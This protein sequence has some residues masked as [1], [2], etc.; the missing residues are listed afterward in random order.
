[1]DGIL[2]LR[3][4]V[5]MTSH[6]CV[7]EIR[8]MT[9]ERRV[10]HAGTLD[11]QVG[12]VLPICLGQATRVIEYLH[13]ESKMYNAVCLVGYS[14]Q[15]EDHTGLLL[16]KAA[17]LPEITEEEARSVLSTFLG[18]IEQTPPMYSAVKVKG[19]RLYEWAREGIEVERPARK[20][21]IHDLNLQK[22]GEWE[23]YPTIHFQVTCSKGTYIRTLCVDIGQKWGMPAHMLH[24][25][26][27]KSGP[28]FL[29]ETY[30]FEQIASAVAQ[31]TFESLLLPIDHAL[32][33][34][35]TCEVGE[36]QRF[37][38]INGQTI[39]FP[40]KP[41]WNQG[42]LFRVYSCDGKFLA[43]YEVSHFRQLESSDVMYGKPVKV[44]HL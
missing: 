23:G 39:A 43:L 9:G 11:P 22:I 2:P 14:T 8:R 29:E 28:F 13:E 10:G 30:T 3:K 7:N 21:T 5:G 31:G 44:F 35:P 12:G 25:E 36:Q 42:D 33:H 4:P 26:R 17:Q 19:K 27:I 15:T 34:Y 20:V 18:E 16:E 40:N 32:V 24:L 38:I 37:N 6:D 1:M 41:E